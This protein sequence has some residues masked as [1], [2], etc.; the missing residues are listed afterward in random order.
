[1]LCVSSEGA[2]RLRGRAGSAFRDRN[3]AWPGDRT[4]YTV[5]LTFSPEGTATL[6]TG[7]G[8]YTVLLKFFQTQCTTERI[9][10]E[11]T[12]SIYDLSASVPRVGP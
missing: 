11:C 2:L 4:V 12:K 3:T 10:D 5:L 9:F 7:T 6:A 8:P 1:M